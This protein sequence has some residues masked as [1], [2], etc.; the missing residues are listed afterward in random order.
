M[1]RILSSLLCAGVLALG[2][3]GC[4]DDDPDTV[5]IVPVVSG[6]L[7]V[8]W[9]IDGVTDPGLCQTAGANAFELVVYDDFG[10]FVTEIEAPCDW[11][12]VSLDLDDGFYS[13][14]ATLIDYNDRA[15]TTTA[16]LY[17]L[18]I[19]ADTDLV[20]DLDFPIDSFL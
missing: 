4:S 10:N 20:V 19:V 7:T 6:T 17:D 5:V 13:A 11:F 16:T 14:D 12:F 18:D 1:K 8:T 15:V 9:T 2:A 3:S